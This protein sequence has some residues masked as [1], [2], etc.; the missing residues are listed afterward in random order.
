MVPN[1]RKPIHLLVPRIRQWSRK[2][3][4]RIL[5]LNRLRMPLQKSRTQAQIRVVEGVK[6]ID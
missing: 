1:D 2:N 6:N 5:V 4:E 3:R